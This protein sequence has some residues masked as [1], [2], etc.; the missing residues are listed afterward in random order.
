MNLREILVSTLCI[1]ALSCTLSAQK[2]L[3]IE[4]A[5]QIALQNN[6]DIKIASN[7]LRIDEKNKSLA[8]AGI[9][10]VLSGNFARTNNI[11]DTELTFS[12]GEERITNGIRTFNQSYGAQLQWT[13]FDGF[14]MFARYDQL[15][16]LEAQGETELKFTIL[17]T[18]SAIFNTY[19]E[20]TQLQ[21][22]LVALDTTIVI[23]K[24]RL[25][26]AQ[27]RY[28]IGKA[29]KLEV[30]NAE[31]DLNTDITAR[32]NQN[33]L[34]ANAKIRLNEI[35]A[36]DV[37]TEFSVVDTIK[38]DRALVLHDLISLATEQ[39]PELQL[40]IINK[41]IQELE[42]K[43][44]K[45]NRMPNISVNTGY[46]FT[47]SEN[48]I[49]FAIQSQ[50]EGL[51]YGIA[52]S[53]PIFNGSLQN[54]NEQIAKIQLENTEMAI[55]RQTQTLQSQL[56]SVYQTYLTNLELI[57][58]E[59]K[60]EEIAK[61]NLDITLDKFNIGTIPAVEFRAAQV[62]YVNAKV[63]YTNSQF[64]AKLSEIALKELSGIISL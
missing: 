60:N 41:K 23:S 45:A 51:S 35:L 42:Q 53:I 1:V 52:A 15:K 27:N 50:G 57:E 40:Q 49:G 17:T 30:L 18:V 39:N 19:Y 54:R 13:I 12:N 24:Q 25:E 37:D 7:E 16:A 29:S 33:Q 3:T 8:N 46:N 31:V 62:N 56:A 4:D 43:Q 2:V 61:E 21:Q 64:Q 34:F 55:A 44:V 38:V 20:I 63:R 48:P 6:F 9:L 11:Q 22:Q 59:A 32:L 28:I 47:R 10:P 58:L 5:V 26:T 14:R 36:R